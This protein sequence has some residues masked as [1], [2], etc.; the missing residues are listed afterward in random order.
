MSDI[1]NVHGCDLDHGYINIRDANNGPEA[2]MRATI[3]SMWQKY[4][5][6]SDPDFCSG[7]ARDLGGRFWEMLLGCILLNAG[8]EL[9]PANERDAQGGQPDLCVI[10]GARRIWIEAIAPTRGDAG[11]DQVPEPILGVV[12]K[13]PVEQTRLRVTSAFW[14]KFSKFKQYIEQGVVKPDDRLII[15]ISGS[16]FAMQIVDDPPLPLTSLFPASNQI[17]TLDRASGVVVVHGCRPSHWLLHDQS[18]LI[19][20]AG[21]VGGMTI[22]E[23]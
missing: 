1:F 5:P 21:L 15:A 13:V 8:Y 9:L 7:F 20:R 17:V 18:I 10:E 6:Y 16:R 4:R 3:E 14:T 11:P 23:C 12:T 22:E 2:G 19:A